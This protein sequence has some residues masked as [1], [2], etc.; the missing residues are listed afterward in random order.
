M[1]NATH[2]LI[3][4]FS[5]WTKL[6]VAV[7]WLLKLKKVLRQRSQKRKEIQASVD[8]S[9]VVE[10]ASKTNRLRDNTESYFGGPE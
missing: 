9:R 5:D 7:A 4:H 3:T 2:R 8:S 6:K 1:P 10:T